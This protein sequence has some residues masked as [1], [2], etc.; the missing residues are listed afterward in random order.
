MSEFEAFQSLI[1]LIGMSFCLCVVGYQ[2]GYLAV[3]ILLDSLEKRKVLKQ[4]PDELCCC[5]SELKDHG[6][7]SD[8]GFVCAKDY[9]LS[10]FGTK[11]G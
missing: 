6:A 5:G 4:V 9:Y 8:H 1:A 3:L 11:R 2:I 10:N 7:F